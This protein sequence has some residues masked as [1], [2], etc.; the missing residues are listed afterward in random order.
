MLNDLQINA[1][2]DIERREFLIYPHGEPPNG[3]TMQTLIILMQKGLVNYNV[4]QGRNANAAM[5]CEKVDIV[6]LT[7]KGH[8]AINGH[9]TNPN[10][11]HRQP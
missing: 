8:S 6:K 9:H 11:K 4:L 7:N 1:L 10:D 5:Q 3:I 2:K